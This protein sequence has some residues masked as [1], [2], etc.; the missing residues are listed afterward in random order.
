MEKRC[1]IY[2]LL[3]LNN[4]RLKKLF[5]QS[6]AFLDRPGIFGAIGIYGFENN[7]AVSMTSYVCISPRYVLE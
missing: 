7:G 6:S 1:H 4:T 3:C 2:K 5:G